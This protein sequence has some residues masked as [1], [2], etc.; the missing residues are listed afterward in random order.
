M[1]VKEQR[2]ATPTTEGAPSR[3][4]A[5]GLSKQTDEENSQMLSR[6]RQAEETGAVDGPMGRVFVRIAGRADAPG[7]D[8]TQLHLYLDK[9]LKLAEGEFFR[10]TKLDGVADKLMEQL[11]VNK[12]GVV[13]WTEFKAFEAQTLSTVAPGATNATTAATAASTRFGELDGNKDGSLGYDELHSG[14]KSALPKGTD[15]ADLIA[16]LAARI[17]LD[18]VDTDQRSTDVKKRGLSRNEW[19]TAAGQM[20]R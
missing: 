8:R 13:S 16:Q 7:F 1:P 9:T 12:D 18:A 17:A 20:A 4:A 15:H 10:G 5:I 14:T 2:T 6:V 11:D 3:S 19:T